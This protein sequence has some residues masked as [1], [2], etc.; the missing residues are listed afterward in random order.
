VQKLVELVCFT[1]FVQTAWW[2]FLWNR[3]M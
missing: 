2:W 3:N 1:G